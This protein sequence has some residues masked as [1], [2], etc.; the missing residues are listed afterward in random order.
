MMVSKATNDVSMFS[1]TLAYELLDLD[2][3]IVMEALVINII[4]VTRLIK[5]ATLICLQVI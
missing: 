5:K 3:Q 1:H 2:L 4:Y